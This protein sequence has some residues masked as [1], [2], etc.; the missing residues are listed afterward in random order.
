MEAIESNNREL[1]ALIAQWEPELLELPEELIT[2]RPDS[3][4]WSIKETVGHLS[5]S[6]SNNTHR[7]IHLQYQPSPLNF[8]DY[9]N[10]GGNDQWVAIQRYQTENWHDLVR[11]W[12]YQNLHLVHVIRQVSIEKLDN[13]WINAL[14]RKVSLQDM[15]LDYL[16]HFKLHLCEIEW[17]LKRYRP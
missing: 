15:I 9:A 4:S 8:P 5:D 16:R 6:A 17:L 13:V 2:L 14:G 7:I 3:E 10:L 12:K 1:L 11:L